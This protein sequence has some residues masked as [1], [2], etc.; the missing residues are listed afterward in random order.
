MSGLSPLTDDDLS[1]D[2]YTD[3]P[4]TTKAQARRLTDFIKMKLIQTWESVVDAYRGRAWEALGY[5]S[6]DDYCASEFPTSRLRLP[7]EERAE[8]ISSLRESGLSQRAISAA[9]G[10]SKGTVQNVLSGGQNCPPDIGHVDGQSIPGAP[11]DSTPGRTNRVFDALER[12]RNAPVLGRNNKIYQ[13]QSPRPDTAE[14]KPRR[15][16]ITDDARGL[17]LE[18]AKIH[19]KLVKLVDDD[20]FSRHRDDIGCAIRPQVAHV[21]EVLATIDRSINGNRGDAQ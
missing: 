18:L 17:S 7:R 12:A 10:L 3:N 13:P 2:V 9:T 20:R 16:P 8:V 6:W 14:E 15:K 1:P 19:K 11:T 5:E 21:L 4:V